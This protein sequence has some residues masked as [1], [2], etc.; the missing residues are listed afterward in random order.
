MGGLFESKAALEAYGF[1]L[2]LSALLMLC[3]AAVLTNYAKNFDQYYQTNW[4]DIM[5]YVDQSFFN[6]QDMGCYGGKYSFNG[7]NSTN[8]YDLKCTD[9]NQISYM[10]ED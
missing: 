6:V 4:G 10:W 1:V 3:Y 2:S 5:L 8:Y 7:Q 9:K